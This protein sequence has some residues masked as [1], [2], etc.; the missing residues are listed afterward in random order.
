MIRQIR[1]KRQLAAI[2]LTLGALLVGGYSLL[3]AHYFKL[4]MD[5]TMVGA[6]EQAVHQHI[7]QR[8]GR[9]GRTRPGRLHR[10][11]DLAATAQADPQ[12][13]ATAAAAGDAPGHVA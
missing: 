11:L 1:L 12:L 9:H 3:A 6:M 10:H 13:V 8:A 7:R 5:S 4:G 2:L